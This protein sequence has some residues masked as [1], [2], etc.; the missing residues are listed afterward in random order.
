M[1][2]AAFSR[3]SLIAPTGH[4]TCDQRSTLRACWR[5]RPM[6]FAAAQD[7]CSALLSASG[8]KGSRGRS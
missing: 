5:P 7:S 4:S 1:L 3:D 2:Q 8:G 6:A